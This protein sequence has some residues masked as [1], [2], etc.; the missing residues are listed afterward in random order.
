MEDRYLHSDRI[1]PHDFVGWKRK[2][3]EIDNVDI[4]TIGTDEKPFRIESQW[5]QT[6]TDSEK[7]SF[8]D[9]HWQSSLLLLLFHESQRIGD[10]RFLLS[11]VPQVNIIVSTRTD[12]RTL[13][14][15]TAYSIRSSR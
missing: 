1:I 13:R 11:E 5:K 9:L 15:S 3:I 6:S 10:N 12:Q 7:T 8:L 4:A 2:C 14:W